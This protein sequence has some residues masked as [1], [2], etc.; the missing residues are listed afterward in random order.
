MDLSSYLA[1]TQLWDCQ[2]NVTH[3]LTL[4]PDG[5]VE[6]KMGSVKAVVDPTR[7]VVVRP[8]G[9]VVPDEVFRYAGLLARESMG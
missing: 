7:R 6:V 8:S 1:S 4:L 3:T 2:G 5:N 9:F